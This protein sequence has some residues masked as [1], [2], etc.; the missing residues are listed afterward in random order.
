MK[1]AA[2]VTFILIASTFL[3]CRPVEAA[4]HDDKTLKG[5]VQVGVQKSLTLKSLALK[6]VQADMQTKDAYANMLPNL[7]LSAGRTWSKSESE[8]SGLVT[9]DISTSNSLRLSSSWSV[10]DHGGNLRKIEQAKF[11]RDSDHLNLDKERQGFVYNLIDQYLE[12]L[13]QIR[14]ED[15]ARRYLA[16]S[17]K[18]NEEAKVLVQAGAKTA[19][20][21]IDTEISV[22]DAERSLLEAES[23]R[24]AAVRNLAALMNIP[25]SELPI[26]NLLEVTPYYSETFSKV[27]KQAEGLSPSEWVGLS[28]EDRISQLSL[29]KALIDLRSAEWNYWPQLKLGVSHDWNFDQ[30]VNNQSDG[31]SPMLQSTSVSA[32]LS[33]TVFDW[34]SGTRSL[35]SSG[36]DF[37]VRNNAYVDERRKM[38]ADAANMIEKYK[39]LVKSVAASKLSLEKSQKQLENSREL[40]RLGRINLLMMQQ[41]T[42]RYFEAESAYASRL[43]ALYLTMAQV[44]VRLGHSIEP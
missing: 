9:E 25:E 28:R 15:L 41:S 36:Y 30:Q 8:T 27:L 19:V 7:S 2:K 38:V 14:Q 29:K 5:L 22:M 42:N 24:V 6:S 31:T 35:Q 1:N 11:S 37:Q 44:I 32:T 39:I 43:K 18:T 23:S 26:L 33:W 4:V 34:F 10:W 40:H 21:A 20:E 17:Q 16:Q 3:D 13:L 12:Y